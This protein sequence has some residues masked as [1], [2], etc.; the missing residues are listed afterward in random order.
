VTLPLLFL[1]V[2]GGLLETFLLTLSMAQ[3]LI[4]ITGNDVSRVLTG[5][6]V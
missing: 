1:H 6:L 3:V 5:R 2:P 4:S